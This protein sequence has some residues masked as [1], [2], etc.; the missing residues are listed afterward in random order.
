MSDSIWDK[1]FGNKA[2]T[3]EFAEERLKFIIARERAGI[4]SLDMQKLQQDIVEVIK[5]HIP[6]LNDDKV[7]IKQDTTPDERF[8]I[9]SV[10][11]TLPEN[12]KGGDENNAT[13]KIIVNRKSKK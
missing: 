2:K 10:N 12:S 3:A 1:I 9:I 5:H 8:E 13:S 11:I 4:T 7:D 6:N